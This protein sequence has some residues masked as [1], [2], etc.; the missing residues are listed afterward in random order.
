MEFRFWALLFMSIFAAALSAA[1]AD[2]ARCNRECLRGF[3]S[4]YLDSM[5]SHDPSRLP[6][7]ANVTSWNHL[8]HS[9]GGR[10]SRNRFNASEFRRNTILCSRQ[11]AGCLG[12]IQNIG[13]RNPRSRSIIALHA[14]E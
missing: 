2:E 13:R 9:S 4:K 12:R 10:G 11:I 7:S 5:M 6:H 14:I 3:I 1:P 8:A